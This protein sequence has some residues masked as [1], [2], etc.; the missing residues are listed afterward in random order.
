MGL[1][2]DYNFEK[3]CRRGASGRVLN[4]DANR[5]HSERLSHVTRRRANGISSQQWQL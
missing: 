5:V 4:E 3:K 1:S 2:K